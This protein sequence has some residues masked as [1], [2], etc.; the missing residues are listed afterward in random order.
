MT[1]LTSRSFELGNIGLFIYTKPCSYKSFEFFGFKKIAETENVIL[2]ENNEFGL[3]SYLNKLEKS[4][5]D[6]KIGAVVV[7]CNPFTLGHKYLIETAAASCDL[8]HVFVVWE[9]QSS[10]SNEVRFELVTRGL[11]EF[12]NVVIHKGEDYI[13][14]EATFPSYF[15]K[16]GDEIIKEH[17]KLDLN[18]FSKKIAPALNIKYRFAGEEP[19][20][21]T[22]EFYNQTMKTVLKDND[23]EFVI[24]KRKASD[25]IAISASKVRA[26]LRRERFSEIRKIVPDSTYEYLTSDRAKPVIEKIKKE[27]INESL[28]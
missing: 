9:D 2:L 13:V 10:F 6:G 18:L 17:T 7:N 4:N 5:I 24:L 26:L 28:V 27:Y 21:K 22:T 1:F 12:K 23:I 20:S 11:K 8:L 14:S 15:I 19:F 25:G 16:S 3:D